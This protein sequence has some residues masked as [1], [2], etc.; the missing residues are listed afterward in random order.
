MRATA[1]AEFT[2]ETTPAATRLRSS[3]DFGVSEVP[4]VGSRWGLAWERARGT[5][6]PPEWFAQ[7]CRGCSS[8]LGS[9]GGFAR[10]GSPAYG[11]S[12]HWNGL[13]PTKTST[14][15]QGGVLKLTGARVR[16]G[17]Q[18]KVVGGVDRW[19]SSVW[20]SRAGQRGGSP[21]S[22]SPRVGAWW[23]CEGGPG[24]NEA[25]ESPAEIGRASCRE[26]VLRLV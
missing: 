3:Q 7:G 12:G 4:G 26:R 24:V 5:L 23:R 25:Q 16:A 19:P 9:G 21:G 17:K 13:R 15:G 10:R 14:K 22:W 1:T 11:C 2:G 6:N 20:C 18:R 8:E